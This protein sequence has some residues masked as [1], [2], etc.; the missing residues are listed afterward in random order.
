MAVGVRTGY[1][2]AT[3][4]TVTGAVVGTGLA[5]GGTPAWETYADIVALWLIAPLVNGGLAYGL[6]SLL[7]RDD[8]PVTCS[9]PALVFVTVAVVTAIRFAFLGAPG[10]TRSV[11]GAVA[12]TV[13][14]PSLPVEW[15]VALVAGG[16]AALVLRRE[17]RRS[18]ERGLH[19]FLL[20]LG[21][22]V[23][24]SAGA[25][26]VGLAVG[27]VLPLFDSIGVPVVLVLFG[28]GVGILVGSWTGAPR[29]I[30]ALSQDYASLG[31]RR[32]I[33]A[34]LPSFLMA[35]AAV[36][37]GVPVSF[38]EIIVSAIVGS[39]AAVNG[40]QAVDAGNSPGPSRDG[41]SRSSSRSAWATASSSS[42]S[43]PAS[44]GCGSGL[45]HAASSIVPLTQI[46]LRP[47]PLRST[48]DAR[49]DERD[50]P[51]GHAV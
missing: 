2:I 50:A 9:V 35:Q 39:S 10:T 3:A 33:S 49:L 45:R 22:L 42:R 47:S 8:V 14:D 11:G 16:A 23:A 41:S 24:F 13:G 7:P 19:R 20:A 38:N 30:K 48:T 34:L 18:E 43:R 31:P 40:R 51:T 44:F 12:R 27:P 15:L 6:A 32:S 5:L 21:G 46:L 37:L 4:F 1:P 36:L 25:S 28:G 26:Q 17:L 29:M